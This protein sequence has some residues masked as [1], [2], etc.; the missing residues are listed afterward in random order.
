MHISRRSAKRPGD[1][2][3]KPRVYEHELHAANI[4]HQLDNQHCVM[5][6]IHTHSSYIPYQ[7]CKTPSKMFLYLITGP[8]LGW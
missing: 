4:K 7:C 6:P 2:V 1:P 8:L 3:P 5:L